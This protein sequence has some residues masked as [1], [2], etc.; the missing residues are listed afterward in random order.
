MG[1]I[2]GKNYEENQWGNLAF[3]LVNFKVQML[4]SNIFG[5]EKADA[6]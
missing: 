3:L 5:R 4:F 2:Y 6:I 1:K